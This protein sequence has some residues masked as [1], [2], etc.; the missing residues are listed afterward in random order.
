MPLTTERLLDGIRRWVE[1]ESPTNDSAG[2]DRVMTLAERQFR[3]AGADVRRIPGTEG[4]GSHLAISS[5]WGGSGPGILVLCH[6]DTVHPLGTLAGPLP[7]RVEGD[8]AYGPGIYDMK[9]GAYLAYSAYAAI[10]E[11]GKST[12]LPIR[13]LYVSDEEVGSPTSRALIEAAGRTAKYVLVVEPARD[14]GKIVVARKGVARYEIAAEGRPAHA[15][16]RHEDGRSAILEI[17]HQ[18]VAIESMTDYARGI[19][20]NVGMIN[21][22]TAENVV[23]QLCHASIDL[24]IRT[25]EDASEM[26]RRLKSLTPRNPDVKLTVQGGINR[27][28]YENNDGVRRLFDHARTIAA[29]LGIDLVGV[30]TGGGSDGNFVA[31][32]VP[33]L[34]GLGV[35]GDG[36]HTHREHLLVSSLTP[37]A[38]LL[39]RLYETLQ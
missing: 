34:D 26:D 13:F 10:A 33:T 24:R 31:H 38:N 36:A 18:V 22:G 28:P 11:S 16:A 30:S 25:M 20:V 2:V 6:L 21:G 39:K 37:R 4:F 29:P 5:S 32:S 14:G 7:Y 15:G 9:G 19:T 35:D 3:E 27:P 8:R 23:P 1:I 17:A 12:P